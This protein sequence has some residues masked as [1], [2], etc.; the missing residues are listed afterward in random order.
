[1][2]L[3]CVQQPAATLDLW[4]GFV[5]P[6]ERS[7]RRRPAETRQGAAQRIKGNTG[8]SSSICDGQ[9]LTFNQRWSSHLLM[10]TPPIHYQQFNPY[11]LGISKMK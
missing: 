9:S 5:A 8:F 11:V 6:D 7:T 2:F 1:M 10:R 3:L 4:G